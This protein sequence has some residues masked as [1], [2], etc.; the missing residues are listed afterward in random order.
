MIVRFLV[1][2]LALGVATWLLPGITLS[3]QSTEHKIFALLLTAAIF[4]VVNSLVKPLFVFVTSP[5]LL[6]TMGVFLLVINA[7]LL[8]LTSW[9]AGKLGIGWHVD[10]FWSAFLGAL[11]VSTVS[12]LANSMLGRRGQEHR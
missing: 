7:A 12:F 1:N 10:G 6:V 9:V 8:I 4:G 11:L 3:A 5:V 2:A